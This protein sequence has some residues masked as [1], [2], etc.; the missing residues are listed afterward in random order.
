MKIPIPDDWD[1]QEWA[2]IKIR[3]PNSVKWL[4]LLSGFLTTP[5]KGRLWD[6]NTGSI[7][8]VQAIG[9][10]IL[11]RNFPFVACAAA[12]GETPPP[13]IVDPAGL[14]GAMECID[15]EDFVMPCLDISRLIKIENGK[16]WAKNDCCEWVEIGPIAGIEADISEDIDIPEIDGGG[17]S[18]CGKA[19]AVM[20][21]V[22]GVISSIW[23]EV[24]NIALQWWG[25]VKADNPGVGM[26]AKWIVVACY[27]AVD[28]VAADN[29]LG[30]AY[31]PDPF[32]AT[33]WQ[34]V[35][36]AL[37]R[38]FS[39][40]LPEPMGGNEIRSALQTLFASEWGTDLLVNAMFVDALRGINRESFENAV[41][42]GAGDDVDDCDCPGII[43]PYEGG[44]RWTGAVLAATN[45]TW[46]SNVYTENNGKILNVTWTAPSGNYRE[47][48]AL[49]FGIQMD[50]PITSVK[51]ELR[52]QVAGGEVP[53]QEWVTS[54]CDVVDPA[55][56]VM[57]QFGSAW[58][59][60]RSTVGA[61]QHCLV[62]ADA[63]PQSDT[64][65]QV[66]MRKCP[67]N[68]G[69]DAKVYTVQFEI[70]EINGV[71]V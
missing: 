16:L 1:G 4:G 38:Q 17:Y 27:G 58:T 33:T 37:A 49:K 22:Y 48:N 39:D 13:T 41:T 5:K 32:D 30:E 18:A 66:S 9:W 31:D 36:C 25:H 12:N 21:M 45:P 71:A 15:W 10:E 2:C 3:W 61:V 11:S 62:T 24:G 67:D 8:D 6:E 68:P 43:I 60:V 44:V 56:W 52:P 26:D 50:A 34:S 40:T 23:D 70:I 54:G 53:T 46:L 55:A 20:D 42:L 47:D 14:G 28:I 65:V 29:A 7:A 19:G 35:K 64:D 59:E 69:G 51:I 63:P 57:C